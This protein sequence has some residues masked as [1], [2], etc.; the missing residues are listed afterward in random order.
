MFGTEWRRLPST[1]GAA[2]AV[3]IFGLVGMMCNGPTD[4]ANWEVDVDYGWVSF[5]ATN[6]NHGRPVGDVTVTVIDGPLAGENCVTDAGGECEL[7]PKVD[8]GTRL[9]FRAMHPNFHPVE[10]AAT[11]RFEGIVM[12]NRVPFQLERIK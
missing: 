4:L 2:I 11:T 10:F 8:T 1:G 3:A 7:W 12:R 9:K 5:L 6:A